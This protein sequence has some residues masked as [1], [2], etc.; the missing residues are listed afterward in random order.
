MLFNSISFA[1]FFAA[2]FVV[3]WTVFIGNTRLRNAFILGASYFFYGCWD[4]RFL[5]LIFF[6]SLCDYGIGIAIDSCPDTSRKI[7]KRWV[8]LSLA[9]NLG[10]LGVFKY[11]NFFIDSAAAVLS[12]LGLE[13]SSL[14]LDIVLPVGIS[15]Y[16]F[17][18]LS[19]T[20][21]VYRG[22]MKATR[23]PIAFFAFVSFFPQLVA[24]PIERAR[25]LLPQFERPSHFNAHVIRSGFLLA[26]WG[27]FKKVV[28]ADRL[29]LGVDAA[30]QD[31]S[32]L[33]GN[34][35]AIALVFF[36]FQLYLDFSA[37]SD[38]AIGTARMLGI[39]LST[40][41]KRPY[42]AASFGQFWNRWH[43]SLSSWF[44]DYLYI[45][46][47]GS[48]K[49]AKRTAIH[50]MVVFLVSGLWHGASWNFVIWGALNGLFLI[51]LDPWVIRPLAR[52]KG[53]GRALQAI[54]VTVCWTVSLA[55]FRA[56]D[57]HDALLVLSAL[58]DLRFSEFNGILGMEDFEFK[59]TVV[60]LVALVAFE[61]V[62]EIRP[63][64]A[65]AFYEK[66]RLVRWSLYGALSMGILLLGSFG[67]NI[68]D[69]NFIYFQF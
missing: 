46:L 53:V 37:Y 60:L 9:I 33:D 19:Y 8:A 3:F 16:T 61:W 26:L 28:I 7:K 68:A 56:Q 27:L 15:F 69:A 47:G 59:G 23:D 62:Q 1:F 13:L 17:Q 11:Y 43:I 14:H 32:S 40:N 38:I 58:S 52:L 65:D 39:Q 54:A 66:N 30:F 48:K 63:R 36:A 4:W 34:M 57:W 20:L 67:L 25:D 6:S 51:L 64:L 41:F 42:L 50:V 22:Q 55:F 24:G 21:D 2:I 44:R 18:T 5:G 29:A 31:I 45:P 49:G 10:L 35:A 12:P